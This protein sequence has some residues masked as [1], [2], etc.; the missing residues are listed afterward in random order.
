MKPRLVF[1][2]VVAVGAVLVNWLILGDSSPLHQYFLRRG[3]GIEDFW[4]ALNFIPVL[5]AA[6]VSRNPGGGDELVYSVL[7][8]IQWF[9]IAFV[10]SAFLFR[11]SRKLFV[12]CLMLA[13]SL[14]ATS[15]S[16]HSQTVAGP[17]KASPENAAQQSVKSIV[18][19]NE[20]KIWE[21]FKTRDANAVSAL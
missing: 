1:S 9:T 7:L 21:A 20:R 18:L 11:V 6:I 8:F 3:S 13:L 19:E 16:S 12:S 14:A 17:E 10:A 4:L 2:L 5:L 15:C